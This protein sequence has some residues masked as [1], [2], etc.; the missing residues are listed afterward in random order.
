LMNFFQKVIHHWCNLSNG[1]LNRNALG[2]CRQNP[3]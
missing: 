3:E 2:K 1:L